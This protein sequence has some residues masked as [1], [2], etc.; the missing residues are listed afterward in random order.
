VDAITV[1][2][3]RL[4]FRQSIALAEAMER[5]NL[6]S[7]EKAHRQQA[8]KPSFMGN[9][10]LTLARKDKLRTRSIRTLAKQP[11][12]FTRLLAAHTGQAALGNWLS[13]GAQLGWQFLTT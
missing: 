13:A 1:E 9:L 11:Q 7:Y 12:L 5:G 4:A 10:L 6:S 8:R 2:G 3:L